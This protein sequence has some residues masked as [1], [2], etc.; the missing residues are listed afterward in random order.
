MY[1]LTKN[2]KVWG[3]PVCNSSTR[4]IDEEILY[5]R[6][7]DA[8]HVNEEVHNSLTGEVKTYL[9]VNFTELKK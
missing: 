7:Y 3:E 9:I 5:Q 8:D 4:Y 1:C 6:N 2:R